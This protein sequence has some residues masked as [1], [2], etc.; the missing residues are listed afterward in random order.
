[1]RQ[2]HVLMIM[3]IVLVIYVLSWHLLPKNELALLVVD[4]TVPEPAD[5]RE[6]RAIHWLSKH[7]R[8]TDNEGNFRRHDKDYIGYH[9]TTDRRDILLDEHLEGI[10]LLYL[11]DTY[12]IY[13]YEKGLIDYE[14]RLPY[15]Y[16]H[17]S[18]I[19]GG[20]SLEEAQRI[21]DF[22]QQE[23][24]HVIGEHNIFGYPTY[25]STEASVILQDT[26]GVKYDGW[27]VRYYEALEDVA[28]WIKQLYERI[29]GKPLDLTGPG[30]VLVREDGHRSGWYGDLVIFEEE[31]LTHQYPLLHNEEHELLK[32]SSSSVP[33]LYWMEVLSVQDKAEVLSYYELPLTDEAAEE[34]HRRGLSTRIPALVY[35]EVPGQATRVY[36]GGDFADQLPAFLPASL[37]GSSRIQ[38]LI[39]YLPGIPPHYQFY[40][41]WYSPVMK[42]IMKRV[43]GS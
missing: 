12:G 33:Y 41:R 36:F 1:M 21:R 37:L 23:G 22:A 38:R 9:P 3:L 15:E 35:Y 20:F 30:I 16:Q 2:I 28:F 6:H 24:K 11:A 10:E 4:K 34:L 25:F 40:F 18:L 29:Y 32:G 26:F 27:L 39:T 17:I 43:L 19:Y 13:N 31:H 7:W 42:N 14:L 5:Y 8:L